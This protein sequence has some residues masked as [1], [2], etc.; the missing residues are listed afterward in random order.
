[1]EIW[2]QDR[3]ETMWA[4]MKI[5]WGQRFVM[6][7]TELTLKQK[8]C[9]VNVSWMRAKDLRFLG[10]EQTALLFPIY[11]VSWTSCVC[12]YFWSPR[13]YRGNVCGGRANRNYTHSRFALYQRHNECG[14]PLLFSEHV[15]KP[16][17]CPRRRHYLIA[18][19]WL[20]QTQLWKPAQV[21]RG[22][23]SGFLASS[24][25]HVGMWKPMEECL[26]TEFLFIFYIH[27]SQEPGI[28]CHRVDIQYIIV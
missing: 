21:K 4:G 5:E 10:S 1:M 18:Q 14:K 3:T 13:F 26:P 11:Q 20:L 28:V 8:S 25:R 17:F 2:K 15:S 6:S 24:E 9:P 19:G 7:G 23:V 16:A 27:I 22:Q 12:Q